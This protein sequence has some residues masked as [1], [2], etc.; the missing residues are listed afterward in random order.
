MRGLVAELPPMMRRGIAGT[1]TDRDRALFQAET[2][3]DG[4]EGDR[5]V[6]LD[7]VAEAPQGR[8]IDTPQAG[9]EGPRAMLAIQTIEDR[10]ER[11]EGLPRPGRRD[12]EEVL[13]RT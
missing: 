5:E 9:P 12:E 10:Q 11:G 7:V 13:S 1:D 2:L 6:A 3:P 4:I 8:D